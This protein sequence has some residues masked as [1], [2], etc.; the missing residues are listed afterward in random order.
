MSNNPAHNEPATDHP[1][2]SLY[3]DLME[4]IKWRVEAVT[5]TLSLV[6]A[7]KY[8]LHNRVAAEFCVLQLRMCCELLAIG[9]LVIHTDVPQAAALKK[10]WNAEKIMKK[11][12]ALKPKFF[13]RAVRDHRASDGMIEHVDVQGALTQDE[14]IKSYNQFG[15]W[16]HTGT[17]DSYVHPDQKIYD[18][19]LLEEFVKKLG[20]LLST[21]TYLLNDERTMLRVIMHNVKDG[22]VWINTLVAVEEKEPGKPE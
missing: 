17:L 10:E 4:Y 21:H 1:N 13:P 19:A 22:R 8:Y 12:A 9:C 7:K 3:C 5:K 6:R 11:V 14:L 15:G 18:I 2:A 16:L 20:K